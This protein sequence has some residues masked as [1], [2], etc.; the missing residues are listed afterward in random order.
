[1]LKVGLTGGLA[2][3]KSFV[4]DVLRGLGAHVLDAD[5]LGHAVLAPDGEAYADV[6]SEFGAAAILA[7]DG[8]TIDRKKLG[9]LAFADPARLARL[10]A[11]VHPRI[12]AR[13]QRWLAERA[14]ADPGGV[15][16][17]EAAVMIEA[18][19]WRGYD[20]L[21]VTAC[22]EEQ[23]IARAVARGGMT[24][25]AARARLRAQLTLAEKQ[26]IV[27]SV[28]LT[29]PLT[30]VDTSGSMEETRARVRALWQEWMK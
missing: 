8:V 27:G 19:S 20:K 10:N 13:E 15:A 5:R 6:L 3:G 25:E 28:P 1:M 21:V 17:V 4:A 23:Q 16:V 26:K 22:P 29:V 18:G 2:T 12:F 9:A 24:E 30:V 11:L 7:P 14:A